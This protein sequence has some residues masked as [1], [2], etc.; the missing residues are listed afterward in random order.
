MSTSLY[1]PW[2]T[3]EIS[4]LNWLDPETAN[5]KSVRMFKMLGCPLPIT[6]GFA[7]VMTL[8]IADSDGWMGRLLDVKTMD[9]IGLHTATVLISWDRATLYMSF[10]LASFTGS[11]EVLLA[12]PKM[13]SR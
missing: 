12:S 2:G 1:S 7:L 5:W 4:G 9:S 3:Y 8:G 6:L 11:F 13:S 10:P